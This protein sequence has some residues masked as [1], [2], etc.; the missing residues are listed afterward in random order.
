MIN[1]FIIIASTFSILLF[2][3]GLVVYRKNRKSTINI[4]F[5]LFSVSAAI[6][7]MLSFLE[8]LIVDAELAEIILRFDFFF[9][10]VLLFFAFLFLF[11]FPN[12]N[13]KFNWFIPMFM[14]PVLFI[15][16]FSFSNQLIYN[17]GVGS[18][19]IF[20]DFGPLFLV[21]AVILLAGILSG[22]ANQ[23]IQ[24]FKVSGVGRMQIKYVLL[25]FVVVA[26][27]A[28]FNLFFQNSLPLDIFRL[29]NFSPLF[30]FACIFYAI[31]KYHLMDI[32]F[33]IR[34]G[35][36]F[37][38]LLAAII[39]IYSV[40]GNLI[41]KNLLIGEPWN[42]IIP[43]II[44]VFSFGKIKD[45]LEV[46]SDKI[47][48]QKKYRF[49]DMASEI[50]NAIRQAGLDLDKALAGINQSISGALKL[51]A[52][53]IFIN[54]SDYGFLPRHTFGDKRKIK[55]ISSSGPIIAYLSD[56]LNRIV[57]REELGSDFSEHGNI[58]LLR[59]RLVESMRENGIALAA[60][61][62]FRGKL[63]GV[64][65]LSDKLSNDYFSHEDFKLIKHV[66]WQLGFAI[67]NAKAYE[68]LKKLDEE[69]S[70][71]ISVVSHQFRTPLTASR[72][73]M[74]LC[75]DNAL[76]KKDRDESL[77]AAYKGVLS[78]SDQLDKLLLVLEIEGGKI[79]AHCEDID[80]GQI[81]V[82]A[83]DK[84]RRLIEENGMI[85]KVDIENDN[86]SFLGDS[87]KIGKVLS[88]L[89]DNALHYGSV[90]GEIKLSVRN[91]EADME[92]KIVFSVSD[93]GMGV[94]KESGKNLAKKFYRGK[95]AISVS[96]DGIGLGL[97][98]AKK[99]VAAHDG[100]LW[101]ENKK[102][103]GVVF[104]VSFPVG[105][106]NVNKK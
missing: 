38:F 78:I 88:I 14:L 50:E 42:Y 27:T 99:M 51:S 70:R 18:D 44:I 32:R 6:W 16:L 90:G 93:N 55:L 59:N 48:F 67:E 103:K 69:K 65:A 86:L 17:V 3:M 29:V 91:E 13:R 37:S 81:A 35:A 2:F 54:T 40:L 20:F 94:N 33:I 28:L 52:A 82:M 95:D 80:G 9:G 46:A 72:F 73:N 49:S 19:G 8:N 22:I 31:V 24:Y 92:R 79:V 77:R 47:F 21:Y 87:D 25:G 97:F 7:S 4:L 63:I 62:E 58:G 56:N 53:T 89:L 98:I 74:E 1:F 26:I 100:E 71:F 61:I 12:V 68:E 15:S 39:L 10:G 84:S 45:W 85:L 66:A 96:P 64:Y 105:G 60:P 34:L 83:A 76:S 30:L 101:Y 106:P 11:N 75:L 102:N 23:I 36:V 104:N 5:F 41:S 57:D 43:S